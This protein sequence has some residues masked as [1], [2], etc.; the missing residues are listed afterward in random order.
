MLYPQSYWGR[1]RGLLKTWQK[2]LAAGTGHASDAR[3]VDAETRSRLRRHPRHPAGTIGIQRRR[4][5]AGAF[6]GDRGHGEVD[7]RTR[8]QGITGSDAPGFDAQHH[9]G[10]SGVRSGVHL[11]LHRS[12]T[13]LRGADRCH[14]DHCDRDRWAWRRV[15]R[16]QGWAGDVDFPGDR[17]NHAHNHRRRCRRRCRRLP[18]RRRGGRL[19]RR[20]ERWRGP[21]VAAGQR[22]LCWQRRRRRHGHRTRRRH[23][24]SRGRRWRR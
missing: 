11:Q 16:R 9:A 20:R 18:R 15:R 23:P 2:T 13:G 19:Q 4:D 12:G 6:H 7:S 10:P 17:R 22:A 21:R 3:S 5:R 1:G 8:T 14:P 24:G